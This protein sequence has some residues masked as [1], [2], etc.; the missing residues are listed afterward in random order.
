MNDVMLITGANKGIGYSMATTWLE[1]GNIAI[2]LDISCSEI[3]ILKNKYGERL[4]TIVCDL[5]DHNSVKESIGVAIQKYKYIDIAVH[6][7][8][9]CVFKSLSQ[10]SV[11][12]YKRVLEVNFIGA[13]N[14]TKVILP[15]MLQNKKGRIC[16][17]SSGVGVT[18]FTNISGYSASKGAIEAFAKCMRLENLGNDITFHILH[19]PL[20]NTESSSPLPVPKEFKADPEKVGRGL[21]NNIYKRKFIIAPSLLDGISIKM[22]YLFPSFTGKLLVKMTN[23]AK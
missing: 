3:D 6:N 7:A 13:V 1:K 4:M 2:V 19:P 12:E 11:E 9:M 14:L 5:S 20:T 8:C 18:G 17:T 16:Y 22:S 15:Y 23:R 10:H 21:I